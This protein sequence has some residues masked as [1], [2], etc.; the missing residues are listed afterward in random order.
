MHTVGKSGVFFVGYEVM[1]KNDTENVT[2]DR[3]NNNGDSNI[4]INKTEIVMILMM[5]VII[6]ILQRLKLS[7]Y[8]ASQKT[9]N[10]GSKSKF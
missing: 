3:K 2:N 4:I 8:F 7:L 10:A 9:V 6:I 5:M 1:E